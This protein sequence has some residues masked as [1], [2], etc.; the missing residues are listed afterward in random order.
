MRTSL[1]ALIALVVM[2]GGIFMGIA[3]TL[4]LPL[5]GIVAAIALLLW[6]LQR[7]AANKPPI[8]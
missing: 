1:I 6:L 3:A 7:R 2:L 8:R 5:I 4:V